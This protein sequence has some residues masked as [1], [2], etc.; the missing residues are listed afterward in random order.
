MPQARARIDAEQE[1]IP[2]IN[3]AGANQGMLTDRPEASQA[4]G[5]RSCEK[6]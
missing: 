1:G 6:V 3:S 5:S 2:L 4:A